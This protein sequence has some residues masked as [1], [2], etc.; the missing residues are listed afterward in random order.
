MPSAWQSRG[1]QAN[2]SFSPRAGGCL[3]LASSNF[4]VILGARA[5]QKEISTIILSQY[6]LNQVNYL[7]AIEFWGR[8]LALTADRAPQP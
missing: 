6:I 1:P 7:G 3:S 4:S 2:K 5:R 8:S